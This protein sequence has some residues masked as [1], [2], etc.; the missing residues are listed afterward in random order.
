MVV[1]AQIKYINIKY[2]SSH[3]KRY[4]YIKALKDLS[5]GY[6]DILTKYFEK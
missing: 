6:A 3:C 1:T 2:F 5:P 4:M